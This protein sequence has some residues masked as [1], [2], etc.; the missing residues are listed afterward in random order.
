MPITEIVTPSL[1]QDEST[2]SI[3]EGTLQ[4][5]LIKAVSSAPGIKAPFIGRLLTENGLN[6]QSAVKYA[7][8]LGMSSSDLTTCLLSSFVIDVVET[9]WEEAENFY[10]F[11]GSPEFQA[12]GAQVKPLATAPPQPQIY[13]TDL[14]PIAAFSSHLTE[15]FRIKIGNDG[16]DLDAVREAWG[17]FVAAIEIHLP[18]LPSLSG[19]SLNLEEE[20]FLGVVGWEGF[21]VSRQRSK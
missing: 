10:A 12:F 15:V 5:L 16:N 21:E 4:P 17:A 6:V 7:L 19:T 1:K 2:R 11:F 3:F 8:G 13:D 9:E 18:G 20:L 14:S